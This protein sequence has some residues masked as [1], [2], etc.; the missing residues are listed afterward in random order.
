MKSAEPAPRRLLK[1]AGPSD[2]S[3]SRCE[4]G[5]VAKELLESGNL[6]SPDPSKRFISAA[7]QVI[8]VWR[9]LDPRYNRL[10]K[11]KTQAAA[12]QLRKE[13]KA[14]RMQI[15]FRNRGNANSGIIPG[16]ILAM[17]LRKI[18]AWAA[19]YYSIY[20]EVWELQGN[21]KSAALVRTIYTHFLRK[22]IAVRKSSVTHEAQ[23]SACARGRFD[24]IAR[25]RIESFK[26]SADQLSWDWA[27]KI[28]IEALELEARAR[29]EKSTNQALF[30]S[31]TGEEGRAGA[32][33]TPHRAPTKGTMMPEKP[34]T[35]T[36]GPLRPESINPVTP[37]TKARKRLPGATIYG[38]RPDSNEYVAWDGEQYVLYQTKE[39]VLADDSLIPIGSVQELRV[40]HP[41]PGPVDRV[42]VVIPTPQLKNGHRESQ[43][44][45]PFPH[46]IPLS[47]F[48]AK[49][50]ELMVK[51]RT[52]SATKYLPKA[53]ILK[54][55]TLLD[56]AKLP[57]RSNLERE[58]ARIMGEYN[59]R[60]PTAAIKSWKAAFNHPQFRRAVRK[61]FSRAEEKYKKATSHI[62][63]VSAGSPR[64]AI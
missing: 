30:I 16:E 8:D 32:E 40:D 42:E 59:Q 62:P 29:V 20:C 13:V 2:V 19:R 17:E 47:T 33:S 6:H 34:S 37:N 4:F 56:D 22:L 15:L 53:E 23:R 10:V 21:K 44:G 57:V 58:A 60:H 43:A 3:Y 46:P 26:R 48:E 14:E 35:R 9:Q 54:I 49:V 12:K 18:D 52:A 39:R 1:H 5:T 61:R 24:S 45:V 7:K 11:L 38:V 25:L 55:A 51:A 36:T 28:E 27:G 63:T 41:H 64:T 31:R 50:G